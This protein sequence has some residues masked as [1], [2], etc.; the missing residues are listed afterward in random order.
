MDDDKMI[1]DVAKAMLTNLGHEVILAVDGDEAIKAFRDAENTIDFVIMDLTIPGGMGGKEAVR[2]ILRINPAA[3]VVVSS[4]YSTDP[5]MANFKDYGF[6]SA[7]VKPYQFQELSKV[8][9]QFYTTK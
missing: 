1:R 3:K 7:L 2:E 5:I 6:C 4:G 8:I 9:S